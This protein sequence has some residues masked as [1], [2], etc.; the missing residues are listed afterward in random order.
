MMAMNHQ[1]T[2]HGLIDHIAGSIPVEDAK[3]FDGEALGSVE[4][5]AEAYMRIAPE[6]ERRAF[7]QVVT[8]FVNKQQAR[9]RAIG[10]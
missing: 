8:L 3:A 2:L 6:A 1:L 9:D 5:R 10:P 7:A 4:R